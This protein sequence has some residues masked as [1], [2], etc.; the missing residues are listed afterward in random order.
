MGFTRRTGCVVLDRLLARLQRGKAELLRVLER[1]EI[2]P[3]RH[4]AR[5]AVPSP[6]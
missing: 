4:R 1:P 5:R 6:R 3:Q 2:P